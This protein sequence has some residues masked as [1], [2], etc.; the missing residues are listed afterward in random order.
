MMKKFKKIS[1]IVNYTF[2]HE[3]NQFK[4]DINNPEMYKTF[5]F[6]LRKLLEQT[7]KSK[8][9]ETNHIVVTYEKMHYSIVNS[10]DPNNFVLDLAKNLYTKEHSIKDFYFKP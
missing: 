4:I 8:M 9:K 7:R 1:Q 3:C 6:C 10:L 2:E 5:L